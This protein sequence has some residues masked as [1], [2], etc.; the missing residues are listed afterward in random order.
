[1]NV[2]QSNTYQ[3]KLQKLNIGVQAGMIR[4]LTVY[5]A[6]VRRYFQLNA[7]RGHASGTLIRSLK[8]SPVKFINGSYKARAGPTVDYGW[9]FHQGSGPKAGRGARRMPPVDAIY[10][11]VIEKN[12]VPR[13]NTKTGK[14]RKAVDMEKARRSLAFLIARK[15]GKEGTAPFPFMTAPYVVVK[16]EMTRIIVEEVRRSL[17]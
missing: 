5:L 17:R 10:A 2:T 16:D 12:L 6:A 7:P 3:Q 9:W 1:M 13:I 11:W 15:I 8:I 14:R 4:A